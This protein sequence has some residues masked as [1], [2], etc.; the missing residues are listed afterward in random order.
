MKCNQ[1]IEP[2]GA[3]LVRH[4]VAISR[5]QRERKQGHR[6]QVVWIT[7]LPGS[8]KSTIAYAIDR[9]LNIEGIESVVLDGDALRIGLCSDLGFSCEDRNENV[10]RAAEVARLFLERGM[11]VVVALVSPLREARE[12]AREIVSATD[13]LEVFCSCPLVVCQ[14]RDPKGHYARAKAGSMTQFTG[15][16]SPYEMPLAPDVVLDTENESIEACVE[17]VSTTVLERIRR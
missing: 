11:V 8:G 10:R 3:D 6:G 4:P 12:R 17:R 14:Q 16:S 13:F 1:F 9:R 5:D 7:G 2:S 15:V